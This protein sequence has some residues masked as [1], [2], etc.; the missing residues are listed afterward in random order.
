MSCES[1]ELAM[2]LAVAVAQLRRLKLSLITMYDPEDRKTARE[3][4]VQMVE[5]IDEYLIEM[6]LLS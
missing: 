2:K 6:G 3:L 4:Q 5:L 1:C